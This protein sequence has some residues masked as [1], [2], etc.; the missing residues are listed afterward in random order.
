MFMSYW[1]VWWMK[2][3]ALM[4]QINE[5]G[6]W[7]GESGREGLTKFSPISSIES[8]ETSW[9]TQHRGAKHISEK[10]NAAFSMSLSRRRQQESSTHQAYLL[11]VKGREEGRRRDLLIQRSSST[12]ALDGPGPVFGR[13]SSWQY[14]PSSTVWIFCLWWRRIK[15]LE[16]WSSSDQNRIFVTENC[17][18]ESRFRRWQ[19]SPTSWE[20][21]TIQLIWQLF[22]NA[23]GSFQETLLLQYWLQSVLCLTDSSARRITN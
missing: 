20:S 2:P 16:T 21:G 10:E 1:P 15:T 5:L 13:R 9:C 4:N 23:L 22:G 18:G 12:V 17:E 14:I 11:G 7:S 6:M 19:V 3:R 8:E